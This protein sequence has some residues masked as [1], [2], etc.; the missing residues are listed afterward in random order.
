MQWKDRYQVLSESLSSSRWIRLSSETVDI[1]YKG[2][3]TMSHNCRYKPGNNSDRRVQTKVIRIHSFVQTNPPSSFSNPWSKLKR[4]CTYYFLI[5]IFSALTDVLC[6]DHKIS[7]ALGAAHL[8]TSVSK[9]YIFSHIQGPQIFILII[10]FNN[11]VCLR[12]SHQCN[13]LT[14]L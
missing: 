3:V 4:M 11:D 5:I 7:S 2:R 10:R 8:C 14:S 12:W 6:I 9:M 1:S 13:I